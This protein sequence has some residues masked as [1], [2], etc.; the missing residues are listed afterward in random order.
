VLLHQTIIGEEA[1]LQFAKA[2]DYPDVLISCVGGGSSFGGLAFPFLREKLAGR[3]QP[4]MIAAEPTACPA[5]TRG[6]YAWDYGD[7]DGL[8]PLMKMHTV[9]HAFI[10]DPIH[11]GGLRY[12]GMAPLVSHV[13]G[14][15]L[16]EAVAKP[17]TECFAAG[18]TFARAEG[19]LP[20]P[21]S[22]HGIAVCIDEA[23]RCKEDGTEKAILVLVTGHGHF[24]MA[25]YDAY[26]AG[27]MEDQPLPEDRLQESLDRLPVVLV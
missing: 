27:G 5:L 4:R 16:V 24:D 9:G 10:P 15:G 19:I 1:L 12:H 22:N 2:D 14:L 13:Y 26:L 20:A 11:A 8:T 23:L 6:R 21:E 3:G 17:Q 18:L 7:S 25:A